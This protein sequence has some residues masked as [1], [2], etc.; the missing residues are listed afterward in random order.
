MGTGGILRAEYNGWY[1]FAGW[2]IKYYRKSYRFSSF[3]SKLIGIRGNLV[4]NYLRC[5]VLK[6]V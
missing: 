4:E 3:L 1:A 2:C 5:E 6:A